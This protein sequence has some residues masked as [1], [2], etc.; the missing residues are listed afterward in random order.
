MFILTLFEILAQSLAEKNRKIIPN[1]FKIE[2]GIL[3]IFFLINFKAN[4][5]Y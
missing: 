3:A 4:E 1:L 2:H 5:T